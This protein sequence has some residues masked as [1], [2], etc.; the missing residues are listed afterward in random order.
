MPNDLQSFFRYLIPGSMLLLTIGPWIP[1]SLGNE[2]TK[3]MAT[4]LG[5]LLLLSIPLGFP[6]YLLYFSFYHI[7]FEKHFMQLA[8]VHTLYDLPGRA[9]TWSNPKNNRTNVESTSS[10]IWYYIDSKTPESLNKWLRGIAAFLHSLGA[11]LVALVLGSFI[12]HSGLFGLKNPPLAVIVG[13]AIAVVVIAIAMFTARVHYRHRYM[14]RLQR[15]IVAERRKILKTD[16]A[17]GNSR[18]NFA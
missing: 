10:S 3:D 2:A 5:A 14:R 11:C 6:L 15:L 16:R 1:P 12:V 18:K 8:E 13:H 17:E 4:I 9:Y 7:P